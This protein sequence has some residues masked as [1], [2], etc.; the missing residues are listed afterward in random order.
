MS[1]LGNDKFADLCFECD[2]WFVNKHEWDQH[3]QEHLDTPETLL[4]C[5]PIVFRNA[6]VKAGFCP[7]CLGEKDLASR[8]LRQFIDKSKWHNHI[9][10]HLKDLTDFSCRHPACLVRHESLSDLEQ[11]LWD[12]HYYRRLRG[13]KRKAEES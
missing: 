7:F 9:E 4:R 13:K 8:R 12:K 5:E 3:C 10:S 11:H 6:L 2:E 1:L